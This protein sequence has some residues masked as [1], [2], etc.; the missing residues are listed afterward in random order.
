MTIVW[1][2]HALDSVARSLDEFI[3][4]Y[5]Q[6]AERWLNGVFH[7]VE[8]LC[9]F[10]K[11]G[12][13][14]AELES[15]EFREVLYGHFRIIYEISGGEIKILVFQHERQPVEAEMMKVIDLES[16]HNS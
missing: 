1:T 12:A 4:N 16:R 8:R 13:I 3:D 7:S 9:E 5:P 11:S 15:G 14:V 10:P 2:E 6:T